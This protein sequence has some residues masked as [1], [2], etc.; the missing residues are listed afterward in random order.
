MAPMD[1]DRWNRWLQVAQLLITL[2]LV[3]AVR[4][5]LLISERQTQIEMQVL[6]LKSQLA[7]EQ[8][9]AAAVVDE[10]RGMRTG[11]DAMKSEILQRMTK[12][13]TKLDNR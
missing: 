4:W 8:R 1:K 5:G 9:A 3:P 2:A 7:G 10:L 6:E 13:E 11:L 12:V